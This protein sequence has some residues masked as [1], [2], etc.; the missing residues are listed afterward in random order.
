VK[1]HL[2]L[3]LDE[4]GGST[5]EIVLLTPLLI[6]ILLLA[7]GLGRL[8]QAR[9]EVEDAAH[10]AARA[11]TLA[12]TPGEA[13]AAAR[14]TAAAA[15]AGDGL[16]C[17]ALQVQAAVG[18]LRPGTSVQATVG[19]TA[20]LRD[21]TGIWLPGQHSLTA[22]STAPVDTYRS[23]ALRF[24]IPDGPSVIPAS[25]ANRSTRTLAQGGAP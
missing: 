18:T 10:Q 1:P 22:T 9:A 19:C 16:S 6:G 14:S 7:V 25:T 2:R 20:S 12:R 11:A 21:L 24:Q 4:R 17:T 5:V 3:Q 8:A 23:V 13:Q 15:L